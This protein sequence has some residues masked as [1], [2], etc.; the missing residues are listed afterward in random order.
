[1]ELPLELW[2]KILLSI[3]CVKSCENLYNALPKSIQ[4]RF[5]YLYMNHIK[6]INTKI[7]CCV[8]N[9]SGLFIENSLYIK[10]EINK[11]DIIFV[12]HAKNLNTRF[13]KIDCIVSATKNG[14]IMFWN[15]DN[16]QYIDEIN[17]DEEIH[18]LEFHSKKSKMVVGIIRDNIELE[19][20]SMIFTEFGIIFNE[21]IIDYDNIEYSVKLLYD[22]IL[23]HIYI[24]RYNKSSQIVSIYIWK[25]KEIYS[26]FERVE[27]PTIVNLPLNI[28]ENGDFEC[29]GKGLHNYSIV[30]LEIRNNRFYVKEEEILLYQCKKVS[31]YLRINNRIYYIIDDCNI[32]EQYRKIT[33]IIYSSNGNLLSKINVKNNFIIFVE[34][35]LF[36]KIDLDTY[37]VETIFNWKTGFLEDNVIELND[38]C[39]M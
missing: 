1:M 39:I 36:K 25:Y 11:N 17:I 8:N 29:L 35:N 22:P 10:L 16:Y 26:E 15:S 5:A 23:P 38:F 19:L 18:F 30:K 12:R 33:K 3:N 28:F 34:E 7:I 37:Y 9:V 14:I 20:Q 2:E 13:G 6:L 24:I 32:I 27:F 21:I 4:D 31:D